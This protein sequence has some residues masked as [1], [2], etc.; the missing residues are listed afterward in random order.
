M[1]ALFDIC[2]H[3]DQVGIL[4]STADEYKQN[5]SEV[6]NVLSM[7]IDWLWLIDIADVKW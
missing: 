1:N 4:S 6:G 2:V 7:T 5:S 3:K